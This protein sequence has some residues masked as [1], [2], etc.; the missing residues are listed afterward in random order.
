MKKSLSLAVILTVGFPVSLLGQATT[1]AMLDS[2]KTFYRDLEIE[3]S[4]PILR[5][6]ISPNSPYEVSRMQRVEAYTYLGAAFAVQGKT[7]SASM[8]F[9]AAI[10]RDPFTDLDATVF[11]PSEIQAFGAAR[12]QT[13]AV[14]AR[15]LP[16]MTIDPQSDV[17]TV[18]V[19]STHAAELRAQVRAVTGEA[20][21][22][23][24]SGSNDGIREV[25]W[26]GLVS[27]GVIA[28][29]G[30]YELV[31]SGTSDLSGRADTARAYFDIAHD[32]P[33]LED[34]LPSLQP[35]DLLPEEH[36]ASAASL[37]LLK[38]LGVAGAALLVPSVMGSGDLGREL[39]ITSGAVAGAGVTTGM[40]AFF[41]RRSHRSIPGNIQANQ[42]R[43]EARAREND[44]IRARNEE[45][46]RQTK[47]VVTPVAGGGQ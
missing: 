28:P 11:A 27:G 1:A 45:R 46:L 21:A 34:S 37:D 40:I 2:A 30:R 15:E 25:E 38:G 42:E 5:N 13:F 9:R 4:L 44:A 18:R 32:R 36:P 12:R 31:V 47:L 19:V 14:G 3:R 43:R 29:P 10:E 24:Y 17:L 20:F 8:F 39:N 6:I 7:D 33:S 16:A 35:N 41:V 22:T 23:L 26:N